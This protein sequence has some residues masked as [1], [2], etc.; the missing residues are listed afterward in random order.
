MRTSN[1]AFKVSPTN[2]KIVFYQKRAKSLNRQILKAFSFFSGIP[3]LDHNPILFHLKTSPVV[4]DLTR[5]M[6]NLST[7]ETENQYPVKETAIVMQNASVR[8]NHS[9]EAM[10]SRPFQQQQNPS[11]QSA[12]YANEGNIQSGAAAVH[13]QQMAG[14]HN[15]TMQFSWS[16]NTQPQSMPQLPN[17][18]LLLSIWVHTFVGL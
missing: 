18:G 9:Y 11:N 16:P 2:K 17:Q 7:Q 12:A 6:K 10:H 4:F 5:G 1:F 13:Q 3:S 15:G 8:S 14:Q